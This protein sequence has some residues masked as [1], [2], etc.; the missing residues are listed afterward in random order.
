MMPALPGTLV[1]SMELWKMCFRKLSKPKTSWHFGEM[2][3]GAEA[4]ERRHTK[5]TARGIG[6]KK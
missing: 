1:T 3:D 4:L 2:K 6:L 5:Q